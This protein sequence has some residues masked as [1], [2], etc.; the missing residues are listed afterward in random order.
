MVIGDKDRGIMLVDISKMKSMALN[1][2]E[3]LKAFDEK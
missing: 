3:G 1:I 2:L